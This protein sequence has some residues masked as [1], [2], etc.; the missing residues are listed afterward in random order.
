MKSIQVFEDTKL[1]L[2]NTVRLA[3]SAINTKLY[4]ACG[5]INS[6]MGTVLQQEGK[7]LEPLGFF[8]FSFNKTQLNYSTYYRKLLA[9]NKGLKHFRPLLEERV[10][11]IWADYKPLTHALNIDKTWPRHAHRNYES[12]TSCH[13]LQLIFQTQRPKLPGTEVSV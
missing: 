12:S 4:L 8:S 13:S 6:G 5:A 2:A 3:H 10:F 1:A 11:T 7:I 9:L